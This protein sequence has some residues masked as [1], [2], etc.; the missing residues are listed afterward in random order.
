MGAPFRFRKEA[1]SVEEN[2]ITAGKTEPRTV[3]TSGAEGKRLTGARILCE[4]LVREGVDLIFGYPGGV[5]LPLYDV[6]PEY[7][8]LR[9]ILVRH[10]QGAGHAADGFARVTGRPGVA[11]VT[12]GPGATNLVTP[13]ACAH[14]DS[15]PMVAITGQVAT[16]LIGRDAFQETDT[17]GITLP[18]TKHNFLVTDTAELA[19]T[20]KKAFYISGTGRPGPVVVDVPKDVLQNEAVFE[21]NET[22]NIRGYKPTVQGNVRQIRQAAQLI[23]EAERPVILAGHGVIISRAFEELRQL[24][25]TTDTPVICTLHGIS[26]LPA[27]HRL[28]MGFP[29][30]HGLVHANMAINHCDLLI[31]IGMRFDDRVTGKLSAFAP[32][33]R[34]IHI[35]IDPAEIGKNV[36]TTVPIVG[37][38]R[39]VLQVLNQEVKPADHADWV[40][41]IRQWERENP[42][43]VI[44]EDAPLP[45]QFVVRVLS[46][47]T[48]GDAIVVA[49]VGQHQMWTA[50][51]YQF[52][53][54][55]GWM[56]SGGLGA[57]GFGVPAAM[58][59]KLAAPDAPVWAVVGDGGFQMTMQEL[60]TIAEYNIAVKIAIIN[61][62]YLGMIRQWQELFYDG[63]YSQCPLRNPDFVKIGEAY[64]IK[65]LRV[66]R[67]EEVAPAVREAMAHAGP[68]LIDFVVEGGENVY[69]MIPPGSPNTNIIGDPRARR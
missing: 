69:P 47:E 14:M 3:Q 68:V 54:L 5:V 11:L 61:N 46:D 23:A 7:P 40:Q 42:S 24:A 60:G 2:M 19:E 53:R 34:V 15:V 63:N 49:D 17:I 4:A 56:S 9:H 8:S 64:G 28:Y 1:L 26:A 48:Q 27:S 67:R 12:S 29:G 45:P 51:H 62:G 25:E 30:M 31:A 36:R 52:N 16:S 58:G 55:N 50:Q 35:D 22:V 66:T 43:L 33:A 59:A 37:D 32:H 65:S 44:P 41:Q 13:I 20:V 39:A 6:L 10:E 21:Y 18:I 38:V 57:M